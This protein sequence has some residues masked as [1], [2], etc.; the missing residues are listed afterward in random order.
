[1]PLA[2]R[3]LGPSFLDSKFENRA[4]EYRSPKCVPLVL[5]TH[6]R[7]FTHH[8]FSRWRLI[9]SPAQHTRKARH[10]RSF[11]FV[12]DRLPSRSL[13]FSSLLSPIS[14]ELILVKHSPPFHSTHT[15]TRL[16]PPSSTTISLAPF[17]LVR[18]NPHPVGLQ[19][20]PSPSCFPTTP[21][22]KEVYG[23]MVVQMRKPRC[24]PT[25]RRVPPA[26]NRCSSIQRQKPDLGGGWREG[27]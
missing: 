16:V 18:L 25:Q 26:K 22:C 7:H 19:I 13:T 10:A 3:A 21:I 15:Y 1:L 23:Q 5:S 6:G 8:A 27:L 17:A 2:V 12:L 20:P 4:T 9:A 14:R 11:Y 24:P